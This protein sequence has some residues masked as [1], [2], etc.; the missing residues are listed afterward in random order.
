M[1]ALLMALVLAPPPSPQEPPRTMR[2]DYVHAG[3]AGQEAFALDGIALEGPWPGHPERALDDT[4]LGKYRFEVRDQ[5]G[6]TLYS[7]G[8]AS[9]YG[10][11]ETTVEAKTLSRA[12]HESVRFPAPASPVHVVLLGRT[13]GGAFEERWSV[14]V[15]PASPLIDRAPP[16]AHAR[17]WAVALNGPPAEKVDLLLLGDGYAASEMEEWHRDARRMALLLFAESPFKERRSDFN[18][19]AL[20]SPSDLSG[21]SRPS[22]GVY[23]R[24]AVGATYDA[25][26]SE[27]YVLAFDN[28]KM[29]ELA[30]AA[31]YEFVEI[32]V[33]DRKYGGGGIH[34]LYATVAAD[35][36]WA[37]YLF[38]HEFG[39]HFAGLADEY[40][41]SPVSYEPS[42]GRPEPWEPNVTAD[43]AA[44]K[45]RD[46]LTPGLERPTPWPKAEFEAAQR[47]FQARRRAIREQKRPEEEMDALFREEK[48]WTTRLLAPLKGLVGAF[49][50]ARYEA[51]GYY[52]PRADCIM[53]TRDDVGFCAPCRRAIERVIDLYAPA[54]ASSRR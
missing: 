16:P 32:V 44:G 25:F 41:T 19:W 45:W 7:R 27:R 54:G 38:V 43:P 14:P 35:S 9:I 17:V 46:L 13:E 29:R 47:E 20:D 52:R 49:E 28:K 10:E 15:D 24:S 37:P 11:W 23:R 4:L 5:A 50:G 39:H 33:N 53:F 3:A 48:A 12:F 8:F 34:N 22:D 51:T 36:A 6:R 18:V 21:V 1:F 26:G 31:P 30:A 42:A 40:Y 2:V